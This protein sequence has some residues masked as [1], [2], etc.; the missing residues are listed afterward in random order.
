MVFAIN[1]SQQITLN[2]S[3]SGPIT[4]PVTITGGGNPIITG[5]VVL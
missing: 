4:V 3:T 2:T 1:N 5:N